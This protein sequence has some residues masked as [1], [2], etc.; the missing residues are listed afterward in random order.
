[1][2]VSL[3]TCQPARLVATWLATAAAATIR[4]AAMIAGLRM[5][6]PPGWR[7]AAP[8]VRHADSTT[9]SARGLA[10]FP[11]TGDPSRRADAAHRRAHAPPD[12]HRRLHP[13]PAR[14]G[15]P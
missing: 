12:R 13:A 14:A 3:S 9:P 11:A 7:P 2:A 1:M 5:T 15:R 4:T 8:A 6:P 10:P